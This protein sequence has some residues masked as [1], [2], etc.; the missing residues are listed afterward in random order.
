MVLWQVCVGQ[1]ADGTLIIN[2]GTLTC[3]SETGSLPNQ[4][5]PIVD[6][7]GESRFFVGRAINAT[8]SAKGTVN[9]YGGK[10]QVA[11]NL[12]IADIDYGEAR[13]LLGGFEGWD[14]LSDEE[15]T[16]IGATSA[17]SV[18]NLYEGFLETA[19]NI[20]IGKSRGSHGIFN[21][22]GGKVTASGILRAYYDGEMTIDGGTVYADDG[23]VW[24]YH[25]GAGVMTL[26]RGSISFADAVICEEG[27]GISEVNV[28]G[29]SFDCRGDW[30]ACG[31]GGTGQ[32]Q[33]S[34][35]IDC[36]NTEWV[37]FGSLDTVLDAGDE[38]NLTLV[39]PKD[40]DPRNLTKV[41]ID[42]DF[43]FSETTSVHIDVNDDFAGQVGDT[44]ELVDVGGYVIGP[45]QLTIVNDSSKYT[46][47]ADIVIKCTG[48]KVII[49]TLTD[50]AAEE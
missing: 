30:D 50:I 22:Y 6:G 47:S 29:G 35:K 2:G 26:R 23:I 27:A 43:N 31:S 44:W 19:N 8:A 34:I 28:L 15:K 5:G 33:Q 4:T 46:F 3:G 14:N 11:N 49:V 37:H 1:G 24:P 32:T 17:G 48:H 9:Q 21:V 42:G 13:E 39:V 40:T 38:M 36:G 41:W 7:N 18:Y 12:Q 20:E 45:E 16:A 10:V 25:A